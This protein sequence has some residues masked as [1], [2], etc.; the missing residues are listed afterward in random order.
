MTD[1]ANMFSVEDYMYFYAGYLTPERSDAET[2]QVIRLLQ[3]DRS[4][5]VLDLACG[6][7]RIANRLALLGH[8]VTGVEYQPGFLEIAQAEAS[9]HR[10]RVA[11]QGGKVEYVQ[12]DMRAIGY[13][14][15]FERA[16]MM[17]NSFG[18]FP[19]EENRLVLRS[20]ARALKPGGLLGFDVA[21]RDGVLNDFHPHYVTEKE[22]SLLINRFSFDVQTGRLRNDRI[23]IRD[24]VR[25]DRPFS[26]RLYSVTEMRDLLAQT[27]FTLEAIYAEWDASPLTMDSPSMVV[28]ARKAESNI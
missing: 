11:H 24:G 17:F 5:R 9:R 25:K 15:Q 10:M 21:S 18:Y 26:I 3:M 14:G 19:D 7:G 2:A 22:D 6:F 23:V 28:I 27:G 4:M 13:D 20:L 1:V 8:R 12:G 16:I